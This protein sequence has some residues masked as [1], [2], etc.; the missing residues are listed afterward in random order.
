MPGGLGVASVFVRHE[1]NRAIGESVKFG[2]VG[3][4]PSSQ[5]S[6]ASTKPGG[7]VH[8]R[9]SACPSLPSDRVPDPMIA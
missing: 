9:E 1:L 8:C 2:E 4:A 6:G 7:R 3:M 5:A